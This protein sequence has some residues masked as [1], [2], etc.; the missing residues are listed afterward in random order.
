LPDKN[1]H[2][3]LPIM[4]TGTEKHASRRRDTVNNKTKNHHVLLRAS[5]IVTALWQSPLLQIISNNK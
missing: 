1:K 5:A 4:G 2:R 3:Q